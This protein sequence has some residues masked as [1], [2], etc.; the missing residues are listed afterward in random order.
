M[1]R[2]AEDWRTIIAA[3]PLAAE[4]QRAP[5]RLLLFCLKA[6]PTEGAQARLDGACRG[7]EIARLSGREAFIFYPDGQGASRLAGAAID[8]ALGG[9]AT[10]RNWNT[11]LKLA[12][13]SS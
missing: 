8:R 5:Q 6:S 10:G 7:G 13:L 11:V 12:T 3:N 9:R 4:A 2:S 1:I